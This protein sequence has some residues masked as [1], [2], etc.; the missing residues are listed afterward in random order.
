MKRKL[1]IFLLM[2]PAFLLAG[3]WTGVAESHM[4]NLKQAAVVT[5]SRETSVLFSS[6]LGS[7]S[8]ITEEA[9]FL[10]LGACCISLAWALHRKS[11]RSR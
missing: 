10:V 6:L 7:V 2:I 5:L 11:L 3:S 8:R 1:F 4:A 9:G